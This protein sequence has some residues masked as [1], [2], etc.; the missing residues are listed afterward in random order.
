MSQHTSTV[1]GGGTERL[2]GSRKGIAASGSIVQMA[3]SVQYRTIPLG[4]STIYVLRS[5]ET[6]RFFLYI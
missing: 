6:K 3:R 1:N 2:N 4:L 5:G